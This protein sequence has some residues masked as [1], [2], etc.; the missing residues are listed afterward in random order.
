M[1][2]Q[3]RRDTTIKRTKRGELQKYLREQR[4]KEEKLIRE[5]L[6]RNYICL[7][8]ALLFTK[9]FENSVPLFPNIFLLSFIYR[10]PRRPFVLF[11]SLAR[12]RRSPKNLF[13]WE[14]YETRTQ[15]KLINKTRLNLFAVLNYDKMSPQMLGRARALSLLEED[16]C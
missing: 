5:L 10:R 13:Y 9:L 4:E 15:R 14:S 2:W 3:K 16:G 8:R 12:A 7:L 6:S 1:C 11:I